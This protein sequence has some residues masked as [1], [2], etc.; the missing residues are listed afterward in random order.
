MPSQHLAD[1]ASLSSI[2]RSALGTMM[3]SGRTIVPEPPLVVTS[4]SPTEP[5]TSPWP[6][7]VPFGVS[8]IPAGRVP[9]LTTERGVVAVHGNWNVDVAQPQTQLVR[10]TP[11]RKTTSVE[12]DGPAKVSTV[13]WLVTGVPTRLLLATATPCGRVP[14]AGEPFARLTPSCVLLSWTA[15]P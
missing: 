13:V 11:T 12:N 9:K 1:A 7:T 8:V 4:T 3:R 6:V 5:G 2:R 15:V 14:T 10:T